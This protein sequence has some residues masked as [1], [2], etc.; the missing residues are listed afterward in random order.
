MRRFLVGL[1]VLA[2]IGA[3]VFWVLTGPQ[4]IAASALPTAGGDVDKGKYVF[5]A[6]GCASC[7]AAPGAK[8]EDKFKLGGGLAL[9]TPFG[10]FYAPNISPDKE[11][12]IGGWTTAEF[13]NAVMRGVSPGGDHY[14]PSFP[15]LSYQRMDVVDVV[16]LKAFMDT[17]PFVTN[18]A[19]S[20]D[21]PLPFQL[22]RGLGLW[23]L[24]FMDNAPFSPI[25]G[26]SAQVNRGVTRRAISLVDRMPIGSWPADPN[27]KAKIWFPTSHRTNRV[28]VRGRWRISLRPW[29]PG[30][31]LRRRRL[32]AQ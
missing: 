2:A 7:H 22:R 21:L 18:D 23:K 31:C 16:D 1:I 26:A 28:S 15:Y 5:F 10:T 20:H 9:K 13:V 17:L 19:P 32:A 25:P 27:Q 14:Y 6:S 11:H 8:G 29:K 4:T 12:G 24:L 3:I 30:F